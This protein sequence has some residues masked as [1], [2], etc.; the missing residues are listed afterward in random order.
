MLTITPRNR[1]RLW[2]PGVLLIGAATGLSFALTSPSVA[3]FMPIEEFAIFAQNRVQIDREINKPTDMPTGP[4]GS[5]DKVQI[6]K[7]SDVTTLA[8]GGMLQLDKDNRV[9][10][11]IIFNGD[12]GLDK[13]VGV[14]GNV[15][16][17][18]D[19]CFESGVDITGDLTLG[20]V[21]IDDDDCDP[22]MVG[23]DTTENGDPERFMPVKIPGK[24]SIPVMGP[25]ITKGKE[26]TTSLDPGFYGMLT[27]GDDNTLE[28]T[29]P[30]EYVLAS[31][32]IGKSLDL[33]LDLADGPFIIFV[34]G[35]VTI[36]E[37]INWFDLS[38]TQLDPLTEPELA[39]NFW[40]EVCGDFMI[41]EADL[42]DTDT[43]W[44]GT[45]FAPDGKVQFERQAE[46]AGALY[47]GDADGKGGNDEECE[48]EDADGNGGGTMGRSVSVDR[49]K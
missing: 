47:A 17:G 8:G 14:T 38:M 2:I 40:M 18:G 43:D 9:V 45:V 33:K 6:D 34:A 29:A 28:L 10:G 16:A 11:S 48:E 1:R 13:D 35:D 39:C 21:I 41:P 5:N 12:I 7:D 4:I 27:L 37:G 32:S 19:G 25:D 22:P 49:R 31:I 15:D 46:I 3:L 30:G 44:F 26:E 24:Q 23:G 20:G 36:V 42:R